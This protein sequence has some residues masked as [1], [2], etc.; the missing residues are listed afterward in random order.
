MEK[1]GNKARVRPAS[2]AHNRE[3]SFNPKRTAPNLISK[4][5]YDD[6]EDT[7]AKRGKSIGAM[8]DVVGR[9]M[10]RSD[11]GGHGRTRNGQNR[12]TDLGR[13]LASEGKL[14]PL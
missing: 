10:S 9:R 1:S 13:L 8:A 14:A 4:I 2:S 11:L 7:F 3:G 12:T 6:P 5:L